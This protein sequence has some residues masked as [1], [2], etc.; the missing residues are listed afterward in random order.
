MRDILRFIPICLLTLVLG[1]CSSGDEGEN[2]QASQPGLPEIT[3]LPEYPAT[4][5]PDGLEWITNN[6]EPVFSSPEAK[7]GG[8][9]HE[10]LYGFPL[11]LRLVGPDAS[12]IFGNYLHGFQLF[13]ID[14]HPNTQNPIPQLATHW[15]FDEDGVTVYYKLDP[16][17]KWSDGKPVTADDY[18]FTQDFMRSEYIV[19]P[20]A[21]NQFTNDIN[22]VRKYDDHT[23]SVRYS[24]PRPQTD[25]LYYTNIP[26]TPRHF[27]KLDD[28][29]WILQ[30]FNQIDDVFVIE[31]IALEI[32]LN[33]V[34]QRVEWEETV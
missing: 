32:S 22:E 34:Y 30:E 2:R 31:S 12:G 17:A 7:K 1:A 19:D 26:P 23:I 16:N 8:T 3:S 6:D 28:R 18:M 20:F 14:I 25:L 13:L 33:R 4:D 9:Y 10:S 21:N 15:A 29:R 24:T 27:H 11:T 5:L